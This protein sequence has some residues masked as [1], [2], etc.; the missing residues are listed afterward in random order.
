MRLT[1]VN[2]QVSDVDAARSFFETFF[3][4][5]CSYQ[6]HQ[7]IAFF[8]DDS[9]FEFAVSNLFNSPPPVYPPDFHLGFILER[10]DDV[11]N[12][13]DRLKSAGVPMKIE[14]GV[15]GPSLVFHCLGPDAI[16]IEVR[17]PKDA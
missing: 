15:Q 5:R 16:P 3:G 4:L 7:Q 1:H 9:G 13:H 14:L 12:I 17:A 11:R 6:R 10:T 8:E 2:L